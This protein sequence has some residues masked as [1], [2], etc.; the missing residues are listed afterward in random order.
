MNLQV[1][2]L[3][4]L[5]RM[6]WMPPGSSFVP[7]FADQP[8]ISRISRFTRFF[9][10]PHPASRI[11]SLAL[12]QPVG[13]LH[14]AACASLPRPT[15]SLAKA[16]LF[17][18]FYFEPFPKWKWSKKMFIVKWNL[19]RDVVWE[20]PVPGNGTLIPPPLPSRRLPPTPS[21]P[22]LHHSLFSDPSHPREATPLSIFTPTPLAYHK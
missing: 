16:G 4:F 22:P 2:L 5:Y 13:F 9:V 19:L 1:N 8:H 15:S 14:C 10:P 11:F 20:K 3:L 6:D 7:P 18:R 12:P 21:H 17:I